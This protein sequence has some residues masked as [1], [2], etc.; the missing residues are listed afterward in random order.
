MVEVMRS[1]TGSRFG[2]LIGLLAFANPTGVFAMSPPVGEEM[3]RRGR[4]VL[5]RGIR[6]F[7]Q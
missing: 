5:L 7:R 6:G 4:F 1:C 3:E 2:F